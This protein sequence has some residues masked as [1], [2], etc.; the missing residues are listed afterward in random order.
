MKSLI[1]DSHFYLRHFH[2]V[3]TPV[4]FNFRHKKRPNLL[5]GEY[6]TF[7]GLELLYQ[8][9]IAHKTHWC[10]FCSRPLQCFHDS[11][12]TQTRCTYTQVTYEH[13]EREQIINYE[14]TKVLN[15]HWQSVSLICKCHFFRLG[16]CFLQRTYGWRLM[17]VLLL[18]AGLSV[19][20]FLFYLRF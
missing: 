16:A 10:M 4:V 9:R 1:V 14:S 8:V 18:N 5:Q 13:C 11:P 19:P 17:T 3:P 15:W 12:A 6:G 2:Q 7:V 20:L